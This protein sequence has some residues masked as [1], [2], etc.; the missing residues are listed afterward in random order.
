[1][2]DGPWRSLDVAWVRTDQSAGWIFHWVS[3]CVEAL[4]PWLPLKPF[5]WM[6]L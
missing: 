5:Q 1:M 2:E 3:V 4:K 6:S